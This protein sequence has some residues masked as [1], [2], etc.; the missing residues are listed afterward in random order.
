MLKKATEKERLLIMNYCMSE[1][2]INLFIIGDIENFGFD[3]D[4]Q[5]VWIQTTGEK[6]TGIV[7]R[8]HDNFIVYSRELD[9]DFN[10]V[11]TLLEAHTVNIISGK[12]SVINLLY[13][14]V[15]DK[16]SKRDMYFCEIR[17]TSKLVEDT[18]EV[19]TAQIEDAMEIALVYERIEEFSGLYSSG[20]E[21]RYKQIAC[22]IGTKE[23]VH[24]FIRR[25][26]KIVSHGNTTAET[27]VSGMIGGVLT[28]PEYRSQG[29]ASQVVSALCK[30]LADRG[31]S[32]CLFF[33]NPKAGSIY[34]RLG[35]EDIEKWSVLGVKSNE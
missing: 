29:L 8:Y 30:S 31:K 22:R 35:F 26:G 14:L 12:Y 18:S 28:L 3:K 10:E 2:S 9:M 24:M 1:P 19:V 13:P 33:D 34:Y 5:D 21:N 11:K 6:L 7:L 16:F 27:S 15:N 4:F 32:A 23:G 20:I 17:D 25:N